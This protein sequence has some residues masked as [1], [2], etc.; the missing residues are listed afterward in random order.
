MVVENEQYLGTH[1]AADREEL[2][3]HRNELLLCTT[4]IT[5]Y[6]NRATVNNTKKQRAHVL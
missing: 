4:P 3:E 5:S 6:W 1:P 2:Q